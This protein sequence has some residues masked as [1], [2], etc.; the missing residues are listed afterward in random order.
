MET[1]DAEAAA[2]VSAD[3]ARNK[4]NNTSPTMMSNSHAINELGSATFTIIYWLMLGSMLYITMVTNLMGRSLSNSSSL[5]EGIKS[6]VF[7]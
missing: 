6:P 1:F 3:L 5:V 4:Q 2:V 7:I